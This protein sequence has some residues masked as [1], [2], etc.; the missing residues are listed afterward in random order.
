STAPPSTRS[1]C[2]SWAWKSP[3]AGRSRPWRLRESRGRRTRVPRP[4]A[5][6]APARHGGACAA[7]AE[8]LLVGD[9]SAP[10]RC[11]PSLYLTREKGFSWV[12]LLLSKTGNQDPLEGD[13]MAFSL[14]LT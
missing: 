13:D 4:R 12:G 10:P 6:V 9:T 11:R 2:R 3:R 8:G 7:R 14:E 5:S 1:S